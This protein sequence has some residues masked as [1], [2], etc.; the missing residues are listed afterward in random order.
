MEGRRLNGSETTPAMAMRTVRYNYRLRP[1]GSASRRLRIEWDLSRWLWNRCI[2]ADRAGLKPT[3]NTMGTM[4]TKWRGEFDWLEAGSSVVHFD[5]AHAD[6][7]R[8]AAGRLT[9]YQ[10]MMSRRAPKPGQRGSAGYHSAQRHAAKTHIKTARRR[11]DRARKW[12]RRVAES[13]GRM[14]VEDFKVKFLAKSTMAKKAADAAISATK[15]ALIEYADRF[16]R[17]LVLVPPAYTTMT[18]S[19]CHA[20]AKQRLDLSMRTFRC[21]ICGYTADRDRNAARFIRALAGYNQAGV[22]G[23]RH[24]R[25]CVV[26]AS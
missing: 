14:A 21:E 5:L 2:E 6:G 25:A 12:A 23:V 22:D 26:C 11:Q 24:G 16:G 1:G 3:A 9:R 10:R 4:L 15:T 7:T 8:R 13:H 20:R 19:S 18:C 17:A